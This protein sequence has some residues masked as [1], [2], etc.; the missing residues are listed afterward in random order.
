MS[1]IPPRPDAGPFHLPEHGQQLES[2]NLG[3]GAVLQLFEPVEVPA[4]LGYGCIGHALALTLGDELFG[5][6]LEGVSRAD[7]GSDL[8]ALLLGAGV[9]AF[10]NDLAGR[11]AA[12]ARFLEAYLGIGANREL[13]LLPGKAVFEPPKLAAS[14]PHDKQ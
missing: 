9:L 1:A 3:N 13:L 10:R 12:F 8:V 11:V 14:G 4:A 6:D 5:H 7:G 2:L